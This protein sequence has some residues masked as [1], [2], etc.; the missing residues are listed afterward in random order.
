MVSNYRNPGQAEPVQARA[1]RV[2]PDY[3]AALGIE[4]I[5]G[6]EFGL[7]DRGEASPV[8]V[9]EAWSERYLQGVDPINAYIEVPID[10]KGNMRR[11]R[12]IGVARSVKHERLDE[13]ANLPT[14]YQFAEAPL[15]VFWLVTR[16]A[17]DTAALAETVRKRVLA[18]APS[19]D[20]G[21]NQ[22]LAY[23]VDQSLVAQRSLLGALGTFAAMTLILAALGLGAV[24]S[25]AIR[26][27]TSELGLRLAIGATPA[28]VR[29]LVLRQGGKL[30]IAGALLG[31]AVG[32]PLSRL[33]ANRL[34][35]VSFNDAMTWLVVVVVIVAVA[36]FACW[37]PARRAA[38]VD[39][40]VALRSE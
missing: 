6:R 31:L 1:R 34:Y 19:S 32:I 8:V 29:N 33:F 25:F 22:P 12:I 15:P 17:G 23:L 13:A 14:V 27:R 35:G 10:D 39:P 30:I 21:V 5:A 26:R 18:L 4:L 9:D 37:L 3:F 2:G 7:A 28:R 20:I 16:T 40:M 38:R 36:L 24:L 11:A